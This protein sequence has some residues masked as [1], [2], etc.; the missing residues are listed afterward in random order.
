[1]NG[2]SLP[3]LGPHGEGWV[4][5]QAVVLV[6]IVLGGPTGP[7]WGGPPRVASAILGI[8]S[9]I[10]GI[11]LAVRGFLDLG[12]NL[13]PLPRPRPGA[14]LVQHGAYSLVRHPI[15][16]GLVMGSTGWG[17]LMASPASLA[18]AAILFVVLDLKSRREEAWLMEA[19]DGY[20][21]YSRHRRRLIPFV[22]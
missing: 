17:L 8:A 20:E 22:Y 19:V 13:T 14:R 6:V 1:M 4:A 2:R 10:I 11:T 5:I 21:L 18:G 9:L 15:Y 12:P 7:A 3:E 16:G